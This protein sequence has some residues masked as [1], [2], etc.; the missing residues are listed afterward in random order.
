MPLL[1][2]VF[3]FLFYGLIV[4]LIVRAVRGRRGGDPADHAAAVRRLFVY[5]LLFA[6][7]MMAASGV[8]ISLQELLET[9]SDQRG[10]QNEVLA[11][12]MSLV[13]VGGPAFG[14][15]LRQVRSRLAEQAEER[16]S[17]AWAAY[18]NGVLAV[19]LFTF[20][21]SAFPLLEG[22]LGVGEFMPERLAP[23]VVWGLV[24][25]G[26]WFWLKPAYGLPGDLH[27]AVGSLIGLVTLAVGLGTLAFLGA[28]GVYRSMVDIVPDGHP[29]ADV[30]TGLVLVFLGALVWGWHWIRE[31]RHADRTILWHT[32][33]VPIVSL[34]GLVVAL[35][36]VVTLA[37][38]ALVWTAGDVTVDIAA[39]HFEDVPVMVATLLVGAAVW[40]YH[41]VVLHEPGVVERS[42]P[43][44]VYDYLMAAAGL[45]AG[46]VGATLAIV[47]GIEAITPEPIDAD[48]STE[49]R[50][51]LALLLL[52][53][54]GG[55]WRVFWEKV[56]EF[57]RTDPR[58]ELASPVRRVHLMAL[59]GVGGIVVLSSLI[60]I[61]SIALEDMLEGTV[62]G[63]TLRSIRVGVAML[64][65]VTGVAAYHLTVY[66]H[67]RDAL[68]AFEPA[69]APKPP[70]HI[71][72]VAPPGT[73]LSSDL[74]AATGA[75]LETWHRT[76]V[77][78]SAAIDLDQLA[79]N[80]E[81]VDAADTLVIVG[82]DGPTVVP[83]EV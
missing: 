61:L 69:A 40:Q 3:Q 56:Q 53:A 35:V 66:R 63:A 55:L 46:V 77:G 38:W 65:T 21:V 45:V 71:V 37:Y 78:T 52:V 75:A 41:R 11:L 64:I 2:F 73:S 79:A 83:Y 7:L 27:L 23:T 33:V 49:N 13:I 50:L 58:S 32:Y 26:H 82:P 62:G 36:S 60:A 29:E 47:A 59:F 22:I 18:L 5:G 72:L 48:V 19:S 10:E 34:G 16:G 44:R 17:F 6:T 70:R 12:G 14:F 25:A 24:W 43:L 57:R 80:I 51:I 30:R 67:D 1:G 42:E 9:D 54:G 31:Y 8:V 68:D 81:A 20:V 28:D 4:W 39:E 76:D 15:L 74:A